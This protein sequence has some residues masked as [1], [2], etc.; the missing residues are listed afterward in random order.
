VNGP[1]SSLQDLKIGIWLDQAGLKK[2]WKK[3]GVCRVTF[4]DKEQETVM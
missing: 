2:E 4:L 3:T 1:V